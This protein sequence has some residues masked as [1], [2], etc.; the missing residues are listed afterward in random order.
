MVRNIG[1]RHL[2]SLAFCVVSVLF[3]GCKDDVFN[4]EK[5]K[6]T[7]QDKFPVKDIDPQ[8]DWKMTRQINVN[9]SVYEDAGTDYIVRIY[10]DNPLDNNSNAKLLAEGIANN[11]MSFQTTIDCP[12][13]LQIF[14][15]VRYDAKGRAAMKPVEATDGYLTAIFGWSSNT[16]VTRT[17]SANTRT[18]EATNV[19][20]PYTDQ[21]IQTML[22]QATEYAGENLNSQDG[23]FKIT[24]RYES[25][26]NIDAGERP[27]NK[28]ILIVAP[29]AEW[30]MPKGTIIPNGIRIIVAQKGKIK[31]DQGNKYNPSVT[32]IGNSS[33]VLL[34]VPKYETENDEPDIDV[35]N[36]GEIKEQEDKKA[37]IEFK[38]TGLI[39]NR[40]EI[41]VEGINNL[42]STLYNYGEIDVNILT[43]GKQI[44]NHGSIEA[45]MIG[46]NDSDSQT[47][48]NNCIIDVEKTFSIKSLIM[49]P[50]S[51]LECGL[52]YAGDGMPTLTL[53]NGSFINTH[54][55]KFSCQLTAP[56]GAKEYALVHI[57]EKVTD[58]SGGK[59]NGMVYFEFEK[60]DGISHIFREFITRGDQKAIIC[61]A[62]KAPAFI[63]AGNC[64][65]LGNTP[66]E[67]PDITTQEPMPY[68]YVF[69]DNFPR[70]GDYDFN[71]VVL[72]V[73]TIYH[74]EK[75][76][77]N[78]KKIQLNITLAAAGAS[79]AV[80]VGLRIADIKKN[81]IKEIKTGG[82]DRRFQDSFNDRNNKFKYNSSSY[83]EDDDPNIVIPIAGEVHNVFGVELGKLVNTGADVTTNAYTYEII[84][85][86]ADQS[87]TTPLFSKD[88]LDFFICYQYQSMQKRMEVHLYEFWKYGA[89]AAGT[90]QQANLDV[91]GNNTWAICV[92]YGFRYPKE[93][94]NISI[95]DSQTCA[96][97]DF[98]EWAKDR[99]SNQD[100]YKNPINSNVYR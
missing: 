76:T 41:D 29:D 97:P 94:V 13:I 58:A 47:V 15:V 50:N 1:F 48:E 8:M 66:S 6:A 95:K 38:N 88:N 23:I 52:L 63:P 83:M 43:G 98:I 96:Y 16:T 70:V 10:T 46:E 34:G 99:N 51:Y 56:T 93:L 73:Q 57:K 42:Q 61:N 18:Y 14:Y 55:A 54:T 11:E 71:D 60:Q 26:L 24:K 35:D 86:L 30:Y 28:I 78:I 12:S 82:D 27:E 62:G 92:P 45:D 85:E 84:I 91:A 89:T 7:Y 20:S 3:Q 39:Y 67:E 19:N 25:R 87:K 22:S 2:L 64:S 36:E 21:E 75:T 4:P 79:K 69:E 77:N 59:C 9:V 49:A 74:R 81:D 100:W 68:T 72:D 90:V 17:S 80:G 65:G 53:G 5:V 31:L 44:V 33:L 40:G 32:F 37:W